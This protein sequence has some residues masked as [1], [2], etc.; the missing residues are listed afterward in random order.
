MVSD[1]WMLNVAWEDGVRYIPL[2]SFL[3]NCIYYACRGRSLG[4]IRAQ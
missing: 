3:L 4:T 1:E 2:L